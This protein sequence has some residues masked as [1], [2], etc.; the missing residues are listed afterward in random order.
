MK[1][2]TSLVCAIFV[3]L[4]V[5]CDIPDGDFWGNNATII[6]KVQYEFDLE[7]NQARYTIRFGSAEE[8]NPDT[9]TFIMREDFGNVGD[10]V[11]C[12]TNATMYASPKSTIKIEN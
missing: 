4:L 9:K 3:L 7:K 5:G 11:R 8:K 12:G 10:V 1:I 6:K 2:I